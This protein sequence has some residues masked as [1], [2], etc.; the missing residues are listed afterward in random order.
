MVSDAMY[1]YYP[2]SVS[3]TDWAAVRYGGGSGIL[4]VNANRVTASKVD[5]LTFGFD[6][7]DTNAIAFFL[8]D[9]GGGQ[10]WQWSMGNGDG[11]AHLFPIPDNALDIG[12][13]TATIG[14]N[15]RPRTIHAAT[16]I[17]TPLLVLDGDDVTLGANDSA[18]TGYRLLR[19]PNAA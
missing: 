1:V 7:P 12:G 17:V 15:L 11:T 8:G 14:S 16:S 5:V 6:L 13:V 10:Q 18:G 9:A 2:G 19:V 4:G 3:P